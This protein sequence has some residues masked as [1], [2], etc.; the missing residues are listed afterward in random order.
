MPM[1]Q[2][3]PP[4]TARGGEDTSPCLR[5]RRPPRSPAVASVRCAEC[6]WAECEA[7]CKVGGALQASVRRRPRVCPRGPRPSVGLDPRRSP[8]RLS[9]RCRSSPALDSSLCVATYCS[10][11]IQLLTAPRT[12]SS[13]HGRPPPTEAS[14]RPSFRSPP[15]HSTRL[16]QQS[17]TLAYET[18]AATRLSSH[19]PPHRAL[20]PRERA[21]FRQRDLTRPRSSGLR[22]ARTQRLFNAIG[23]QHARGRRVRSP[24]SPRSVCCPRGEGRTLR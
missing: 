15:D 23:K 1:P 21:Q 18:T 8:R 17:N 5:P 11:R 10:P 20:E 4:S 2:P 16:P 14:A 24:S 9:P 19:S 12:R 6:R 22:D 13:S 3:Q 7:R